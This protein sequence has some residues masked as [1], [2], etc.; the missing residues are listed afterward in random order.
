M[1]RGELGGGLG[2]VHG[3]SL[4]VSCVGQQGERRTIR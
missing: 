2:S 4:E 1:R 3:T